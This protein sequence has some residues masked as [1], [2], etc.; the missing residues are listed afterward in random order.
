MRVCGAVDA[1]RRALSALASRDWGW[2]VDQLRRVYAGYVRS[3]LYY[4]A[5]AWQPWLS[6]S[7]FLLLERAQNRA[8]RAITG[9]LCTTPLEALRLEAGVTSYR[10]WAN[11]RCA[12]A[13][14][15]SVRLPASNPRRD[16][17]VAQVPHRL[18]RWSWRS[19]AQHLVSSAGIMGR[20]TAFGSAVTSPWEGAGPVS[21]ER[22]PV[23][24]PPAV[25][26]EF[27]V[28]TD[29]SVLPGVP[30]CGFAA[31]AFDHRPG[32]SGSGVPLVTLAEACADWCTPFDAEVR[33]LQIAVDWLCSTHPGCPAV[34]HCDCGSALEAL[35]SPR[36]PCSATVELLRCRLRQFP[37]VAVH[38]VAGH[39]AVGG[40]E[41]ADAAARTARASLPPN[42][43]SGVPFPT[44]CSWLRSHFIDPPP[45]S[46]RVR[47][48]Y[49]V[50]LSSSRGA[51]RG[52]S[53]LLAQLRS[54]HC[55]RLRAY[56]AVVDPSVDPTCPD[57]G[58]AP[59]TLEHWFT[60]CIPLAP[61][62][63]RDLGAADP[64]S[65]S[66]CQ[67]RGW[68][69]CMRAILCC[70]TGAPPNNNNI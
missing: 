5:P 21:V 39:S 12:I 13:Y 49:A 55:R 36:P 69:R 2:G 31:V 28:Y 50:P 6:S 42:Q 18:Q 61:M 32:S 1:R 23:V 57:C 46:E 20:R 38:R 68:Q 37:T 11:R 43:C 35:A 65:P 51:T 47:A 7:N 15:R 64:P 4:C 54:G 29:G 52:D 3:V 9:Q 58:M 63:L 62:R 16:L 25:E 45:T 26:P 19:Q 30:G 22:G 17:A 60:E 53:V 59:Q 70:G 41:L 10:S 27:R 8:L 67:L 34:V 14:E 44:A 40:N 48:V 56:H 33:A 66:S 24:A